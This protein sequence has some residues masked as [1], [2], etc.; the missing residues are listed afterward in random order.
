MRILYVHN[1]NHV[2]ETYATELVHNDH[3]IQLYEPDLRGGNACLPLKLMLLPRRIFSLRH[4]VDVLKPDHFD[5]AHIHWASYGILGLVSKIPF[6]V[7]CHGSDVRHR[8]QHPAF[9]WLLSHIFR[10]SAVV[11]CI[12]PDLLPV[13]RR[14]RPDALFLPGPVDT[15]QFAPV[16]KLS[17]EMRPWTILLFTRL[18]PEKGPEIAVEGILRFAKRHPDVKVQ[19]LDWGLL[20]EAYKQRYSQRFEFLPVVPRE[21]VRQ[22]ILS[23][24]VVVGQFK[25][26]ILSFCELQAMSCAKPVICSFHYPD[27][28]PTLPPLLH[29]T[30]PEEVDKH[31]EKLFQDPTDGVTLGQQA[32]EWVIQNHDHR[33][34]ATRLE[35]LYQSILYRQA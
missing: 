22:L 3:S 33:R 25:L 13:V 35:T 6:V 14:V 24:D 18:D 31:L 30:L 26:G 15:A 32:R 17:G 10:R 28:Y 7:E 1:I 12:T 23:A 27:A 34:L 20:K 9:R 16:D 19:L 11:L 8:L 29:A 4:L 21:Q 5:L 2:A